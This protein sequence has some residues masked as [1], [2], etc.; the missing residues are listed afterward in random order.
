M[1]L[2]LICGFPS[3]GK[4]TRATELKEHLE[5]KCKKVVNI[6]SDHSLGVNRTNV[7]EGREVSD[8]TFSHIKE[9]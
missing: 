6:I 1:P 7:Y 5:D 8:L 9:L 4:T 2:V 3:S